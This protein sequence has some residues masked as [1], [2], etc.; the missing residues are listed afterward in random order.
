MNII[1]KLT[2]RQMRLNK[3]RTLVTIIGVIISVAMIMA[4][5]TISVS[6]LELVKKQTIA[7]EG[8]WHV[9]YKNVNFEQ[10]QTVKE[11][12]DTRTLVLSRDRGYAVLAGSQN[13]HKPYLFIKEY[14]SEAYTQLPIELS[15]GRL[16]Q[17]PREVVLSEEIATNGKVKYA[18]GEQITLTIGQRVKTAGENKG[19]LLTQYAPLQRYI[20]EENAG[21]G[22]SGDR[23][24]GDGITGAK[25]IGEENTGERGETLTAEST[26]TYTVVGYIK[27]PNWEPTWA[28]GYT[29]ISYLD[30]SMVGAQDRVDTLVVLKRVARSLYPHAEAL[31]QKAGIEQYNFNNYL[32]RFY[33]VTA[34]DQLQKTLWTLTAIMLSIIVI[35]SVSLI[36]NAF[37]ISVAERSRDLGMLASVG[38]TK[39]QKRNSVYFEGAVIAL[40]SIPLG[41]LSGLGG[42]GLTF[43]FINPL[44]QAVSGMS[45]ELT[46]VVTPASILL[47]CVVSLLTIFISTYLPARKASRISAIEAIRQTTEV[48][49]A[50]K[51]VKTSKLIRRLL[52]IEAELGL[53]NLKR[54]KR[55]YQ[56]VVFSLVISIVL[57]LTVSYFTASLQK[58]LALSQ[59]GVNF[60]I[61]VAL[62]S[63]DSIA[64]E[65]Y[66]RSIISLADVQEHSVVTQLT[67]FTWLDE[68]IIA[69]ELREQVKADSSMLE[70][71]EY[72]YY[73]D[74]YA[75]DDESLREYATQVGVDF[76]QLDQSPE[77]AGIMVDTAIYEDKAANKI[78]ETKAIEA[79]IGQT[80]ALYRDSRETKDDY[81]RKI[82]ISAL[83]DQLPMGVFPAG[84]GGLN[85]IVSE[86]VMNKL[87]EQQVDTETTLFLR[88]TDPLETQ[89]QIEELIGSDHL[90]VY[91]VYQQRQKEEQMILLM[92]VFTYGFIILIM[93]I[94]IA[95][96]FNT[97]STSI[98]LRKREFAML[99]SV[100][101]TPKQFNKMINY[102]SNFYGIKALFYGLP[103]SILV[104]Y[105]IHRA[106]RNVIQY[107]FIL[108]WGRIGVVIM[109]VFVIVGSAMLFSSAKV[110]KENI[111]DALKK[112]NI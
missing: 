41:L 32:L 33:G 36:Y 16:P 57:F 82:K 10:L 29:V 30:E 102:E 56:A 93:A 49:L 109:A 44:I 80:I 5:A 28:P 110:K 2:L 100:G 104:M 69:P 9:T 95:N 99:K 71:G 107:S 19:E 108:P 112:E 50:G 54:N 26:E 21:E 60:D 59:D 106:I 35:G 111:I 48:K 90:Y 22:T 4:V 25:N 87:T 68:K 7:R 94:S 51:T 45:E 86:Q 97:I 79:K 37:A 1:N 85:I 40:V 13:E 24:T 43:H 39:R 18:L 76:A 67:T 101:M 103:L 17:A 78:V 38:A 83:T 89:H 91:N 12:E 63:E 73:L 77:L 66:I 23:N 81:L 52:G 65:Q 3:R 70:K 15:E 46:V 42:I 105:F 8:E 75:L 88:T 64:T 92:S 20:G 11:D 53:K 14:S 58:A 96:I 31:A 47:A 98:T 62:G 27:R 72:P 84:V 74:I 34:N 6:F 61:S 55:R